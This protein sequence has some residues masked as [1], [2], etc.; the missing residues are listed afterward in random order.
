[1]ALLD[2]DKKAAARAFAQKLFVS[3]NKTATFSLDDIVLAV[4]SLDTFLQNNAANI[5]AVFP[6]PFKS[7]AT[8]RQKVEL[9]AFV[10][11]RRVN[12]TA[13]DG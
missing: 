12:L 6:E 8:A 11:S 1:M 3:E 7:Q 13:K 10:M 5:N 2:S 4:D 9:I